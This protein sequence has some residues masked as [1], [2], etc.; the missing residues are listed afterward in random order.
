MVYR[1]KRTVGHR[2]QDPK[3]DPITKTLKRTPSLRTLKRDLS[4]R[5]L[6]RT[7]SLRTLRRILSLT[8]LKRILRRSHFLRTLKWTLSLWSVRRTLSLTTLRMTLS[9]RML[10]KTLSPE[11][12]TGGVLLKKGVL[13]NFDKFTGK[14]Y[15]G[16]SFLIKFPKV[17]EIVELISCQTNDAIP[18]M[19]VPKGSL[20]YFNQ[21]IK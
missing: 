20:I 6:K 16:V 12:T 2:T 15:V 5:T 8:T 4:L 18:V 7:L 19:C 14:H 17:M 21:F 13:K 9:L 3:E 10:R 11:A 1:K